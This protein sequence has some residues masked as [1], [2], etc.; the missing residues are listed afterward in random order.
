MFDL[1]R[2]LL[3]HHRA[4]L[5]VHQTG[6]SSIRG[7]QPNSRQ[8]PKCDRARLMSDGQLLKCRYARE[9]LDVRGLLRGAQ[10]NVELAS[11]L[12]DEWQARIDRDAQIRPAHPRARSMGR[13]RRPRAGPHL[14]LHNRGG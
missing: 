6:G 14:E 1:M 4:L 8:H 11:R 10:T 9:G 5:G 12:A 7:W 3:A 2:T 13:G